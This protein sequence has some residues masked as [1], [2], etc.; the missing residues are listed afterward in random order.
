MASAIRPAPIEKTVEP[1]LGSE[2]IPQERCNI[3]IAS[4]PHFPTGCLAQLGA[5]FRWRR[6]QREA[7]PAETA[8]VT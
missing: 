6:V 8:A 5:P 4:L 1:D 2:P 7:A 3:G